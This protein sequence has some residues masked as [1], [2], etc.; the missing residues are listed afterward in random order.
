MPHEPLQLESVIRTF[1]DE[2]PVPPV[3]ASRLNALAEQGASVPAASEDPL[4]PAPDELIAAA[5]FLVYYIGMALEDHH[6]S[7]E[8]Q[9]QIL[10]LKRYLR[11]EEGDLLRSQRQAVTNLLLAEM[12]LIL[13]DARVESAEEMHQVDLQRAL[14][15][16]YDQFLDL[17]EDAIRPLVDDIFNEL[18]DDPHREDLRERAITRLQLLCTVVPLDP[19]TFQVQWSATEVIRIDSTGA[20]RE[21][22]GIPQAVRDAVWRRDQGRCADCAS[23]THLEFDHIIPFAKGGS[24]TYRNLRL[25]CQDCNR[26]KSAK[27]G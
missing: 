19:Q 3:L 11:L 27:I 16:G 18:R 6:L 25:L 21:T 2:G 22:R 26:K 23:A 17:V 12:G 8:E 24:S 5:A 7:E 9:R 15:L 10:A 14:D 13:R 20:D 1:L 4:E